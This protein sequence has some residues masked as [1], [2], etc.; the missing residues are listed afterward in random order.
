MSRVLILKMRVLVCF[1]QFMCCLTIFRKRF[2]ELNLFLKCFTLSQHKM[3]FFLDYEVMIFV[4]KFY[5]LSWM[6]CYFFRILHRPPSTSWITVT[7]T[8]PRILISFSH[9]VNFIGIQ[10]NQL[11]PFLNVHQY[12][13]NNMPT[14]VDGALDRDMRIDRNLDW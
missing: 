10:T 1:Y 3:K 5:Y 9:F 13:E 12:L 2:F 6:F 14:S 4:C 8:M 11:S 7:K